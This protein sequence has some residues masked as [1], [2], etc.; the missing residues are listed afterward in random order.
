MIGTVLALVLAIITLASYF[1][2]RRFSAEGEKR[3][4]R[5]KKES[6]N[7]DFDKALADNDDIDIT[8]LL[9]ERVDG[10][11]PKGGDSAGQ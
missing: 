11:R 4:N 5:L 1:L 3:K 8:R 10:V 2:K 9:S 7:E 6:D